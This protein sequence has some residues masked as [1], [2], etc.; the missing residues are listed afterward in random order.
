MR[1]FVS[2]GTSLAERDR[3]N[4]DQCVW[5]KHIPNDGFRGTR[6]LDDDKGRTG[7]YRPGQ[8]KIREHG[9]VVME[10]R[11]FEGVWQWS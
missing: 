11:G 10:N 8:A 7:P 1:D 5:R 2:K 3:T 4:H 9:T 6:H